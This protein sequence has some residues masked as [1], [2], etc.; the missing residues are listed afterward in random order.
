MA[1][2]TGMKRTALRI[3]TGR[4]ASRETSAPATRSVRAAKAAASALEVIDRLV[5]VF[6]AEVRPQGI[7]DPEFG[8]GKLPEKEIGNAKL[9]AGPDQQ[10]RVGQPVGVEAPREIVLVDSRERD[11]ALPHV[12][13]HPADGVDDL[14][15]SPVG[16]R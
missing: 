8:V 5:E 3:R 16:E 12:F 10:V 6:A 7:R 4:G 14:R 2:N 13:H 15:S 9:S 1:T 11:A